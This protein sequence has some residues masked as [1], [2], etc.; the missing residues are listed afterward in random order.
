MIYILNDVFLWY[1]IQ[2]H[3]ITFQVSRVTA[4]VCG[5]GYIE[6]ITF[7]VVP[8]MLNK[9]VLYNKACMMDDIYF[10]LFFWLVRHY[11]IGIQS[12]RIHSLLLPYRPASNNANGFVTLF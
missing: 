4:E 8:V 12:Q 11:S 10:A 9:G 7:I 1:N 3:H 5:T 2:C 6:S